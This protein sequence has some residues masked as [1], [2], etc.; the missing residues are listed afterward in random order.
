MT[1]AR[2]VFRLRDVYALQESSQWALGSSNYGYFG[3]GT[4]SNS[5]VDRIDYFNDTATALVRGPLSA[6]RYYSAAV[7]N[8][9][10]GY[11]AGGGPG[12][13]STIDRIDYSNDLATASPK[14]LLSLA[15]SILAATGNSS[16][17]YFGG[18][19]LTPG[20]R[21][22]VDRIDYSNDTA[23]AVAKGSL[24]A[25]RY[26]PA[27]TGNQS[28]GY[29]GGGYG[30]APTPVKSIIDRI[31]YSNDT[32]TASPKGPLSVARFR[33]SA[34]GNS[35]YGW[36][37][38][39]FASGARSIV[40]RVDY[41]NDTATAAPKGPLSVNKSGPA[42]TGNQSYGYF[43]GGA[44]P[45]TSVVDRIDFSNDTGTTSVRGPLSAARYFLS[46]TS[47][48]ANA[49]VATNSPEEVKAAVNYGYFGGGYTPSTLSTIDRINY[50]ND[51]ATASVR[52]PLSLQ[53]YAFTSVGNGS[54]GYFGGG[55]TAP[56]PGPKSLVDSIDYSNDLATASV[57]GSLTINRIYHAAVGNQSYGYF[58]A[59]FVIPTLSSVDRIDYANDTATASPKGPLTV[60][61]YALMATGNSSYGWVGGG[62][63]QPATDSYS[64]VDRI[65]YSN[66]TATASPRGLLSVKKHQSG[67]TGNSNYGYFGGGYSGYSPTIVLSLVDRIDYANDTATASPKGP[68]SIIRGD[69]TATGNGSYGYFG[70]GSTPSLTSTIDR[71]DYSNDTATA[72]L[73]GT[74]SLA[75]RSVSANSAGANGLS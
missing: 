10:Y 51:T 38:G 6:V 50:S 68:L 5:I 64:L 7:G 13:I 35:S 26:G 9:S 71:I 29:F 21:S 61:N 8:S 20:P 60:G 69:N 31:D 16:Y 37:G 75:K 39:G 46:A 57:K 52:G 44:Q 55:Y 11:W 62:F 12:P 54:Y 41:S 47:A 72:S 23:T 67:A 53:R 48:A 74:L 4:P 30:A 58:A 73:K 65:D 32:A 49:L 43:G 27:A 18:G 63:N 33:F 40:D 42:A 24:T 59:G 34:T 14:G 66:D 28:Y 1:N 45:A 17:G 56:S 22:T 19:F 3:G 25:I 2:G 15:R 36:F 70:G